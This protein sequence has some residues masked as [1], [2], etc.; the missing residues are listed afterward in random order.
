MK[1]TFLNLKITILVA[2]LFYMDFFIDNILY[3]ALALTVFTLVYFF[4]KKKKTNSGF[5]NL[6]NNDIEIKLR[7]YERLI[8][9]LER[10]E[11]MS[12]VNRLELHKSSKEEVSSLLIKNIVLEYEYNISQQIYV[13]DELWRSLELIKNKM[14]NSVA[15][16]TK[17]LDQ[18][19]TT[20]DL[21]Q[22]LL[23]QSKKNIVIINYAKKILKEEV[24]YI[25]NMR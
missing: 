11:P 1:L 25:S 7:A 17:A 6:S 23:A 21:I 13:S 9:F 19:A 24:R 14:I 4:L 12:M 16:C 5:Q 15:S 8:L 18:T 3:I 10:I 2:E 20:D 22:S